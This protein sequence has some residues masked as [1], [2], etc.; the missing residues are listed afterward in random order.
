[1]GIHR[2]YAVSEHPQAVERI[3]ISDLIPELPYLL[4]EIRSKIYLSMDEPCNLLPWAHQVL[5]QRLI[6]AKATMMQRPPP[7]KRK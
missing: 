7:G 4:G 5:V 3:T 2:I 6:I 1:M